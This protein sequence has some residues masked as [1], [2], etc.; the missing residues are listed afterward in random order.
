MTALIQINVNDFG[1]EGALEYQEKRL[2]RFMK[3]FR[4]CKSDIEFDARC[5]I[6]DAWEKQ[7]RE[8]I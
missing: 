5:E 1:I 2:I 4:H 6:L 7:L 3:D 8:F